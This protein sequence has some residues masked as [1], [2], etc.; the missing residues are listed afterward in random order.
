MEQHWKKLADGVELMIN[1][2]GK[3]KT[4][5]LSATLTVPLRLDTATAVALIPDVLYRGCR[6]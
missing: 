2:T 1:Q 5:M 4:G 6:Q 3:F